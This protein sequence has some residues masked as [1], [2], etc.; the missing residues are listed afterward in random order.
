M[1]ARMT[2]S[3]RFRCPC[4]KPVKRADQ[5]SLSTTGQPSIRS[6]PIA[7]AS[8][9][10]AELILMLV[11]AASYAEGLDPRDYVAILFERTGA[12]A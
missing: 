12:W 8:E 11:D 4:V 5:R 9:Q 3:A 7:L 1:V 2:R 10:A 6:N